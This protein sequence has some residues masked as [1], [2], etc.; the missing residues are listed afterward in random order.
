MKVFNDLVRSHGPQVNASIHATLPSPDSN[1]FYS[2]MPRVQEALLGQ[3]LA[4]SP[5]RAVLLAYCCS[6]GYGV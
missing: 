6:S 4:A 2:V 5:Q 1:L 3:Q